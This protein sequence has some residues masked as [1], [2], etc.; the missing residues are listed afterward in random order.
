MFGLHVEILIK[1]L[2]FHNFVFPPTLFCKINVTL[3]F[4]PN[5]LHHICLKSDLPTATTA[6]TGSNKKVPHWVK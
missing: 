6:K 3:V 2:N 5:T 4:P 1:S